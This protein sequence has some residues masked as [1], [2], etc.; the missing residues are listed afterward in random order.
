MNAPIRRWFYR[1]ENVT[2]MHGSLVSKAIQAKTR[3]CLA[4]WLA[5]VSLGLGWVGCGCFLGWGSRAWVVL[6]YGLWFGS[7]S[8]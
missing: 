2:T 1:N 7:G 8:A 6:G 5:Y 4:A 3:A